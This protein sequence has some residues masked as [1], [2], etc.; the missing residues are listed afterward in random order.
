MVSSVCQDLKAM[1]EM[2]ALDVQA[3]RLYTSAQEHAFIRAERYQ[4]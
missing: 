3:Y 4:I 1:M 2:V